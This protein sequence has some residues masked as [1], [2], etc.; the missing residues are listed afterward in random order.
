[1]AAGNID[2]Q[3]RGRLRVSLAV[4]PPYLIVRLAGE[5]DVSNAAVL[6]G[7]SHLDRPDLCTLLLDLHELTFCDGA[8]VRAL[9]DFRETQ[10]AH[11]RFLRVTRINPRVRRVME[12][13]GI[14]DRFVR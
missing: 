5:L 6:L 7:P 10:L 8:G 12:L 2:G 11:G 14:A 9:L 3:Q 4:E 13:C 1:M